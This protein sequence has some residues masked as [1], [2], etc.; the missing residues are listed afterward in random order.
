MKYT[1]LGKGLESLIPKKKET[2]IPV[3]S[4]REDVVEVD[5]KNIFPNPHQPRQNINQESLKELAF[6]IREHGIL[7][8][9][10]LTMVSNGNYQV[11]AGER[12]LLASKMVGLKKVPAIIRSASEQQKLE[13]ALIENLQ[14][15]NLNPIEE[16]YAFQ[17]LINEFNLNQEEVAKKIGKS[18][19]HV[20]NTLRLL[21]LPKEIRDA[22]F[23]EKLSFGHAKAILALKEEKLQ[24]ALFKKIQERNFSVRET[25]LQV[26]KVKVRGH[27]R[28]VVQKDP[29]IRELEEK[30]KESLGTKVEIRK[31][32]KKGDILIEFYS[33]EEL[34]NL[35]TII[36]G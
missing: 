29:E 3:T 9:L 18:R 12:R 26:K 7:Q 17:K 14:R 23:F 10:I 15:H 28:K 33:E 20:A 24:L 13:Y 21:T 31:H 27:L 25:E 35:V 19:A 34:N 4:I 6:S 1:R 5:V 36:A 16:A 22:L 2:K 30:L 32:G 11:L 8:P